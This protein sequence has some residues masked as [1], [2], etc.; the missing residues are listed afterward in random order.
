MTQVEKLLKY[1]EEDAKLLKVEREVSGSEERKNLA[2]AVNFVTKA[3]ERLEALD[4]KAR[5]LYLQLES[6]N[7]KYEEVSETLDEF[8]NL[9]ELLEGGADI[10]F[11]KKNL[12][13]VTER[14]K[15]I[16][17][18]VSALNK[19]IKESDEE[20]KTLYQK[21]RNM[22]KQGKELQEKY[23]KLKAEKRKESEEIKATLDG[24][25]K[26]IDPLYLKHYLMKRSERVFPI[27]CPAQNGRCSK[28][29][30]EL[31]IAQKE[32]INSGSVVECDNCH[33]FL[34][35]VK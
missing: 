5:T 12:A 15:A 28:C 19:A 26:D 8:Q 3:A 16:R 9:D 23:E 11:Y 17:Q 35:G 34:Y 22:Q 21:N 7:K 24:L 14:L 32:K 20:F 18:E 29:G 31:S 2:Q 25:A 30:S 27:L 10:S 1:Q 33:R 13:Q 6:L 4:A